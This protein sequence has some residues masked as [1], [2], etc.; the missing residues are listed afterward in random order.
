M[1]CL[2]VEYYFSLYLW[3]DTFQNMPRDSDIFLR[4]A[5]HSGKCSPSTWRSMNSSSFLIS[6]LL[7]KCRESLLS[8]KT[9]HHC[10]IKSVNL[11]KRARKRSKAQTEWRNLSQ[12]G[13]FCYWFPSLVVLWPCHCFNF[14]IETKSKR[15][16][17]SGTVTI[18]AFSGTSMDSCSNA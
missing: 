5:Q 7:S 10:W 15:R 11:T 1:I 17:Y 2:H 18:Q 4:I 12:P 16:P 3:R 14:D 8:K 9:P 6:L 13:W